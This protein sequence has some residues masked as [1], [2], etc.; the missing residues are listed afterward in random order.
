MP[1]E[2][3]ED[4]LPQEFLDSLNDLGFALVESSEVN[5]FTRLASGHE[6]QLTVQP[7]GHETWR[8]GVEWRPQAEPDR[9]PYA[10]IPMSLSRLGASTDGDRID[11]STTELIELL[12]EL[13]A[14]SILPRVDLTAG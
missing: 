13:L 4:T 5:T 7:L 2:W 8:I 3:N 12:P 6:V 10:L 9:M 14:N 11:V 1:S